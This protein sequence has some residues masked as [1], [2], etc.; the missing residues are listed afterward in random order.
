MRSKQFV[1]ILTKKN[2][3]M[4]GRLLDFEAALHQT[5]G[6][7]YHQCRHAV[8]D[9]R[10]LCRVLENETRYQFWQEEAALDGAIEYRLPRLRGLLGELRQE[11]DVF[12]RSLEDFRCELDYFNLSGQ[13]RNVLRLGGELTSTLRRCLDRADD[14]LHPIALNELTGEN[15][16]E[17]SFVGS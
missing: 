11:H 9:L 6:S 1:N 12:R 14:E 2:R 8:S 16:P 13:V 7:S 17:L 3:I 4:R 5:T 10:D 15:L